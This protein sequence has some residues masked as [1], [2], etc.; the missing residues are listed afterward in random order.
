MARKSPPI[1]VGLLHSPG[2]RWPLAWAQATMEF[3]PSGLAM[4]LRVPFDPM[5]LAP[6]SSRLLQV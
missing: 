2:P 4:S 6:P 5:I 1:I 3:A